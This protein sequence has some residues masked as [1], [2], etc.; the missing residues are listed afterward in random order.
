MSFNDQILVMSFGIGLLP[1]FSEEAIKTIT[2]IRSEILSDT[3]VLLPLIRIMDDTGEE[4]LTCTLRYGE[5]ALCSKSY[6][7]ANGVTIID[8]G[9]AVS[10]A[11][12]SHVALF[13]NRH[14]VK[15]LLESLR[16]S[17]PFTV[18]GVIPER[19]SLSQMKRIL[20]ALLVT[21]GISIR[22]LA[23]IIDMADDLIDQTSDMNEIS[24][25]IARE[26]KPCE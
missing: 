22:N 20:L 24:L 8:I 14:M 23:R 7:S 1:V 11:L 12:K 3:G 17:V 13:V 18:D 15:L 2:E 19:I 9:Q 6:D 26:L 10:A 16:E 4:K 25:H 5:K 21:Q